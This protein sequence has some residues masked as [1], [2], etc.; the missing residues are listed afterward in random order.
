MGGRGGGVEPDRGKNT[1]GGDAD[2]LS[3]SQLRIQGTRRRA[4]VRQA[5]ERVGS[6]TGKDAIP[7]FGHQTGVRGSDVHEE[8]SRPVHF[9]PSQDWSPHAQKEVAIGPGCVDWN[10]LLTAAK[11]GGIQNYFVEMNLDLLK[12]SYPYLHTLKV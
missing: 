1:E 2:R 8:V 12:A 3:Q 5:D 11:T 4:C 10:K 6:E 7:G 9:A